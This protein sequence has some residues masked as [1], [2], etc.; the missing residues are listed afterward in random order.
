MQIEKDVIEFNYGDYVIA[1]I[2]VSEDELIVAEWFYGDG[3]WNSLGLLKI[4][5]PTGGSKFIII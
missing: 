2:C 1:F 4:D 3:G 5:L